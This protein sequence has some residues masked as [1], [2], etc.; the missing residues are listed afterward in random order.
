MFLA[1]IYALY[2]H[3]VPWWAYL[4]LAFGPDIGMVGYSINPKVGAITYNLFHHKGVCRCGWI[5]WVCDGF[6]YNY[7]DWCYTLWSFKYGPRIRIWFEVY[8]C[9]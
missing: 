2:L 3:E 9:V 4:L 7:S 1:S 6:R 5:D 8:G